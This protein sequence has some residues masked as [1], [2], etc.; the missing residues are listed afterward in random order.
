[1]LRPQKDQ[2][3]G[4]NGVEIQGRDSVAMR[5][6]GACILPFDS[7]VCIPGLYGIALIAWEIVVILGMSNPKGASIS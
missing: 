3:P 6:H 5:A 4:F 1:M 2:S 7:L